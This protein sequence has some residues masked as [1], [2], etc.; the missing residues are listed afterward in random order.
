MRYTTDW[1][2]YDNPDETH[3]PDK[4]TVEVNNLVG[5]RHAMGWTWTEM[6]YIWLRDMPDPT[7][8][9]PGEPFTA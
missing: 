7:P 6:S 4:A 5:A 1:R 9:P 3:T 2:C 8:Q